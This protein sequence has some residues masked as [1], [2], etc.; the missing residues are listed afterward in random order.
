[1]PNPRA[2]PGSAVRSGECADVSVG[3]WRT[4]AAQPKHQAATATPP[5]TSES[6]RPT[7]RELQAWLWL[8]SAGPVPALLKVRGWTLRAGKG[9]V[10]CTKRGFI[11]TPVAR[12]PARFPSLSLWR[13]ES[14]VKNTLFLFLFCTARV[15][16]TPQLSGVSDSPVVSDLQGG[17]LPT[18]TRAQLSRR[19][20]GRVGSS[21]SSPHF[22]TTCSWTKLKADK[23]KPLFSQLQTGRWGLMQKRNSARSETGDVFQLKTNELNFQMVSKHQTMA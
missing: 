17:R 20:Q 18:P 21:P 5:P 9:T 1:M 22:E 8:R 7:P 4:A 13:D 2:K 19:R 15:Q 11:S 16:Q 12:Q 3:S 14:S 10:R 6:D 23:N